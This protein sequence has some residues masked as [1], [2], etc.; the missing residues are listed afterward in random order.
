MTSLAIRYAGL[1]LVVLGGGINSASAAYLRTPKLR[2]ASIVVATVQARAERGDAVAAARLGLLYLKGR[3][4]PQNY[5]LAA[6]WFYRA[7]I[8]GQGDAQYQLA[9]LYNKGIGV[10]RDY[11]LAYMWLNLSAAQALGQDA[12]FKMRMRDAIASK[13]TEPQLRTAQQMA[14]TWYRSP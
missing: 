14:V 8:R 7:A 4:V 5:N 3:G 13:M 10:Q 1:V 12:D 11:V 6:Q 9:M 2:S